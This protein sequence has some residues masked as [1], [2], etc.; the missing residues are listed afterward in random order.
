MHTNQ[1]AF[2]NTADQESQIKTLKIENERLTAFVQSLKDN[3][4]K[5][6]QNQANMFQHLL[7]EQKNIWKN[8]LTSTLT[9]IKLLSRQKRRLHVK[10]IDLLKDAKNKKILHKE[11]YEILSS[12]FETT[13][14]HILLNQKLNKNKVSYGRRYNEEVKKFSITYYHSPK[15]YD[16]CRYVCMFLSFLH[17]FL[18][19]K[20]L[21]FF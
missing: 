17:I 21:H 1:C 7:R 4:K 10:L 20:G 11:S 19:V 2:T 13:F 9:E 18:S 5:Q 3:H 16:F 8:K 6:L 12:E 14:K 15:A